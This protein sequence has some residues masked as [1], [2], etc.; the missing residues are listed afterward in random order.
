M[1]MKKSSFGI[2][3]IYILVATILFTSMEF[4]IKATNGT[5]NPIQLN[6][7]RFAIS[8][9][10][11]MPIAKSML[12]KKGYTLT[13]KDYKLFTLQSLIYI[14]I[15][16]SLYTMSLSYMPAYLVAIVF[17]FNT[18][19]SILL[20]AVFVGEKLNPSLKTAL[21][22]SIAGMA[23]I[24]NPVHFEGSL[25]G[26]V[27]CISSALTFSIFSI[28][29]KSVSKK[30]PIGGIVMTAYSFAIGSAML[31]AITAVSNI[32]PVADFM[33]AHNMQVFANIPFFA[34]IS[35]DT[36][37]PLFLVVFATAVGFAA[38]YM[39][40]DT[41]TV[42]MTSLVFFIKPVLSPVVAFLFFNEQIPLGNIAGSLL[43]VSGSTIIFVQNLKK[44]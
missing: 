39:A 31:I 28:I 27:I 15:C 29:T 6:L 43:I 37:F 1:K 19:F 7:I 35:R 25:K 40:L 12:R 41:T 4:S 38:Y 21:I 16:L 24:A 5:F 18:V 13:A 20:A 3:L 10:I 2:S 14:V 36:I 42:A 30:A 22:I 8:T 44:H 17:S 11:L 33:T 26:F 9:F 32:K 34:G 23:V